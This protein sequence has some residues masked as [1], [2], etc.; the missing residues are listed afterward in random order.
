MTNDTFTGQPIVSAVGIS[1]AYP[2]V[3][4]LSE[5]DFAVSAGEV[6]ALLGANG[7]GKSTLIRALS[8]AERPDSGTVTIAGRQLTGGVRAA[9]RLGVATC[10]QE[11]SLIPHMSVAE[12][13]FLGHWPRSGIAIDYRQMQDRVSQT[14]ASLGLTI[15]PGREVASLTLAQQQI[16]EIARAVQEDPKLLILDEPTSALA[17]SEVDLVLDT[18]KRV[19]QAGVS[20][21]YVSHRMDEIRQIAHSVTVMRDGRSIETTDVQGASTQH[22]ID[23]MLGESSAETDFVYTG[24]EAGQVRLRVSGLKAGAKVRDV[25][26]AVRSGEV[27]GLAGVLGSGRSE[28]LR[29]IAGFDKVSGGTVEVEGR[30]VAG[31]PALP[32]KRRGVGMTPEDRKAE[33]IIQDLSIA[34]NMVMSDYASVS[35]SGVLS[36]Q[37]IDAAASGLRERL[38]MKA[39]HL[40]HSIATLSGGNQ[41]KAVIGRWLHADS[42][43]LLLDE[44]TRGVD[45]R[46]KGQIYDIIREIAGQGVAVVFVSS[47]LEELPLVC[48]RVLVLQAGTITQEFTSPHFTTAELLAAAMAT[49]KE[50]S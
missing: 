12:N 41:Q 24:R 8:G 29:A 38:S 32:I 30:Q 50:A 13:M 6:R 2:G 11:L 5:V 3:Q 31:Q 23:V 49:S 20:V 10:Y 34:E 19:S 46:S 40:D 17:A 43:V 42:R 18:V 7:A 27:L 28:V 1:K 45:V 21:I 44:P 16:V 39:R 37:S 48:D 14:L 35:T 26:L 4:A 9:A 25:S 33:G 36:P 15:D 22:I 47:E